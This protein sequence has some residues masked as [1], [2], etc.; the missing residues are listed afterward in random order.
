MVITVAR[1]HEYKEFRAVVSKNSLILGNPVS[2]DSSCKVILLPL[3]KDKLNTIFE[4][5][6]PIRTLWGFGYWKLL[7][8][9][10]YS[11]PLSYS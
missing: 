4:F 6:V 7:C 9:Q 1:N 5:R 10:R 8:I 11:A 2:Y 3:I